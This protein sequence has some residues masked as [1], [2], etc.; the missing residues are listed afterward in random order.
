ME[1]SKNIAKIHHQLNVMHLCQEPSVNRNFQ[2][3]GGS[4]KN[5]AEHSPF[6]PKHLRVEKEANFCI[7]FGG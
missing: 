1:I 4:G 2:R 5:R 6:L 7:N 3:M